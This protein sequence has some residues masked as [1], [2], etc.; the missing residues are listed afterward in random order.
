[1]HDVVSK[2]QKCDF[3]SFYFTTNYII[4]SGVVLLTGSRPTERRTLDLGLYYKASLKLN[5]VILL[6]DANYRSYARYREP[7]CSPFKKYLLAEIFF[8]LLFNSLTCPRS[9][10]IIFV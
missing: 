8:L 6:N 3:N 9:P 10:G 2:L 5:D 4:L 7:R 1:M